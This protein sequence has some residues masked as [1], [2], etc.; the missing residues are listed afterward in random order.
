M[1]VARYAVLS[2]DSAADEVGVE[3]RHELVE[4]L[5]LA[6]RRQPRVGLRVLALRREAEQ[7]RRA[8][9]RVVVVVARVIDRPAAPRERLAAPLRRGV[10]P[11]V[12]HRLVRIRDPVRALRRGDLRVAPVVRQREVADHVT[13]LEVAVAR[14]R[15]RRAGR[16]R[17]LRRRDLRLD[18]RDR[19]RAVLALTRQLAHQRRVPR[20]EAPDV[21]A[22]D[23]AVDRRLEARRRR[24]VRRQRVREPGAVRRQVDARV[25][26]RIHRLRDL[27]VIGAGVHGAV[28]DTRC[29]RRRQQR[30]DQEGTASLHGRTV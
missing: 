17:R 2:A 18:D 16:D 22:R 4:D 21:G 20:A 1:P 5:R 24:R 13:D 27:G 28:V 25:R 30:G 9:E 3:R 10:V 19:L 26:R 23:V 6:E 8:Q 7:Y 14:D 15:G 12:P 11:H 29:E